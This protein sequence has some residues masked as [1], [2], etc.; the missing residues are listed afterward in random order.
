MLYKVTGGIR[1][2]QRTNSKTTRNSAF[3]LQN[4]FF[5]TMQ[6]QRK[7]PRDLTLPAERTVHEWLAKEGYR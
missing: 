1:Q 4:D 6:Q 5:H 3:Y 2:N 7:R